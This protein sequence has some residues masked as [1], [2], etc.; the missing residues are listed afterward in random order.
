MQL[1]SERLGH[2][3]KRHVKDKLENDLG[4]KV[5]IDNNLCEPCIYGKSQRILFDTRRKVTKPGEVMSGDVCGPSQE[6][7]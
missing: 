2:Q 6:S 3:D 5:E 4:I 1:Y 7:F